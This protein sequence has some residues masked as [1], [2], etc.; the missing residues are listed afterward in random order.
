MLPRIARIGAL[1]ILVGLLVWVG[2]QQ[3]SSVGQADKPI[4]EAS[5]RPPAPDFTLTSTEGEK[6]TLS[7]LKGKSPVLVNFFSTT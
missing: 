1:G 7:S 6:F 4:P 3:T 2:L 5:Q